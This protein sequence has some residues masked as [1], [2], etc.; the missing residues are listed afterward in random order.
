MKR[1]VTKYMFAIA[2]ALKGLRG[3]GAEMLAE[4]GFTL[5]EFLLHLL[6]LVNTGFIKFRKFSSVLPESAYWPIFFKHVRTVI[7]RVIEQL[8]KTCTTN[9]GEDERKL[10]LSSQDAK[11]LAKVLQDS[12]NSLPKCA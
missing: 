7:E 11:M 6:Q 4:R 3:T 5:E 9:G 10:G 1:N 8:P 12:L 2:A